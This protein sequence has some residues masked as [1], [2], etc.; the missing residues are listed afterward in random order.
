MNLIVVS[1]NQHFEDKVFAQLGDNFSLKHCGAGNT[2]DRLLK[3]EHIQCVI[4]HIEQQV[5]RILQLITD[6]KNKFPVIPQ[7]CITANDVDFELVRYF[8]ELGVEKVMRQSRM[9][10]LR[11]TVEELICQHEIKVSREEF[12]LADEYTSWILNKTLA[13]IEKDYTSILSTSELSGYVGVADSTLSREFK[14]YSL[15]NPKRLLLYFKISHSIKLMQNQGLTIKDII[16]LSGFTSEKRYY[17][18]FSKLLPYSP[19][20]CQ[21]IIKD[22]SI[23]KF[24]EEVGKAVFQYH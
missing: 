20:T 9:S 6:I 5:Q 10:C 23:E 1:S 4:F 3:G 17:D 18:F 15:V 24:W 13:K 21:K 19:A 14:K 2:L 11:E 7:L 12:G 22:S 8:G 16:R